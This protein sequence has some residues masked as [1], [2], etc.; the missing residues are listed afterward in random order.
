MTAPAF[1][2]NGV[3]LA[4]DGKPILDG[5]GFVLE[6]GE[7][8]AV[9]GPNGAGKT[10]LLRCLLRMLSGARGEI[11]VFGDDL[12]RLPRRELA[13]RVAYVPQA[14]GR[15]LPFTAREFMLMAR[16]PH[17]DAFGRPGRADEEAV[18]RAAERCG[19][20]EFLDRRMDTLSGG[21]RQ[22]VFVAAAVAQAPRALLLDEPSTFLDY[23][24]QAALG[25]LVEGLHRRDGLTVVSV[26]HD[27]NQ[28]ALTGGKVLALK[29]GRVV[30][31]G[32]PA[33]LTADPALLEDIY[34]TGFDF[35]RHPR[36][37]EVIVAPVRGAP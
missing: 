18:A 32:E 19:V 27:L 10:T 24:H 22:T 5:V 30:F 1:E 11:R 23:R 14:E 34:G 26:T 4:L 6:A 7:S 36:T 2:L 28:G 3:S 13:R 33:A 29:A 12:A 9:I 17:L 31:F 37:G 16:Y 21:E 15:A 20:A 25:D 8:L 35:L